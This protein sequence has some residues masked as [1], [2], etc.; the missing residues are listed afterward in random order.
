MLGSGFEKAAVGLTGLYLAPRP[1]IRFDDPGNE[2]EI[3]LGEI[4][5][6]ILKSKCL[7]Y[8]HFYPVYQLREAIIAFIDTWNEFDAHPIVRTV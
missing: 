5:F 6:G 4:W 2:P 8:D 7:K 3:M 1:G